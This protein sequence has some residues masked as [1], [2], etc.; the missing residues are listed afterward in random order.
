[1]TVPQTVTQSAAPRTG[2]QPV[3]EVENAY[4]EYRKA[5]YNV[6]YKHA[7]ERGLLEK[8]QTPKKVDDIVSMMGFRAE[9]SESLE[10]FLKA[11]TRFGALESVAQNGN[12][13]YATA[14]KFAGNGGAH[15]DV[16]LLQEAI[17]SDAVEK[18]I[19]GDSYAGIIDSFYKELNPVAVDFVEENI[20]LWNE[21]LNTPFYRY[22]RDRAVDAV[23]QPGGK[24]LDLACGPGF[25]L[26]RHRKKVGPEGLVIGLERSRDFIVEAMK[27]TEDYPWIHT[28]Q[29][30]LDH[31]FPFIRDNYF[32]GA[33][34]IGAFHFL[35]NRNQ[36]F[37]EVSRVLRPGGRFCVGYVYSVNGAYD[38][39][40]MDLRFYLREP[41]SVPSSREEMTGL[42]KAN[43]FGEPVEN[44][45]LGCFEWCLFEKQEG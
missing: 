23:S 28:V 45:H 35:R 10:L 32:D 36:F 8:L 40:L 2:H 33:M 31:G 6:L 7:D 34:I 43:G 4:L 30:D 38:Q 44:F 29:C 27:R 26:L 18:L 13:R 15:L 3:T 1:M 16:G 25:S 24:V 14:L 22:S 42:G 12:T 21:F 41:P 5:C 19:H 37:S 9:R 11:L 39:E 17:G 20:E